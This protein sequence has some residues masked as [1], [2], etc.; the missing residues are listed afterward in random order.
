MA[1][2]DVYFIYFLYIVWAWHLDP[3]MRG[4]VG[5]KYLFA[6]SV[7]YNAVNNGGRFLYSFNYFSRE[8]VALLGWS[9]SKTWKSYWRIRKH[10][11]KL[12]CEGSLDD[13]ISD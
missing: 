1:V 3:F 4:K 9:L 2:F 13:S 8:V 10:L 11:R 5:Y 6:L 7:L 12:S